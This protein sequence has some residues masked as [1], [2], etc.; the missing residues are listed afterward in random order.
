MK[1]ITLLLILM[2]PLL[3]CKGQNLLQQG[4]LWSNTVLGHIPGST[5]NSYFIKFM[6][7]TIL[8]GQGYKKIM[9]SDDALHAQWTLNGC[10]R[11]E[12]AT[13]KVYLFNEYT[14][15]DRLLYDF[16]LEKGD[17]I[18]I[19]DGK[20]YA[21]VTNVIHATFGSSPVIRKQICFFDSNADPLWIEGIGS[22]QGV[23][24]G[25]DTF[26]TTGSDHQLVCYS[27]NEQLV[28]HHPSFSSCFPKSRTV[29]ILDASL[30]WNVGTHCVYSG[31]MTPSDKWSTSFVHTE[32]DTLMNDKHY[33]KI[34]SCA[35]S[36]CGLKQFKS[37]IREEAG[38]VM[39]ANKTEE[40]TLYDFN[41]Q[42]GDTMILDYLQNVSRDIRLYIRVDSVKSIVFIQD[43]SERIVQ[44]V[45]V[46]DYYNSRLGDYSLNDVFVEGIGSLKFG[47]EYPMGLFITMDSQCSPSLLCFYSGAGLMYSNPEFN[48]C[49]LSTGILQLQQGKLVQ[50]FSSSHG[51]LEIQFAEAKSGKLIVFDLNGKR[52]LGQAVNRSGTQYCLPSSGIYLY[53]FE[54]DKGKVQTGKVM[55]M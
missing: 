23:L 51:M 7:D 49:Y 38:K 45:T 15:K 52:I 36:L 9:R 20:S 26:F 25:L 16:S 42:K 31:P 19:G 54:S 12:S 47:L 39:L 5:Y 55:V 6:G 37:F 35:D 2:L 24:D 41:L 3:L 28:Y 34:V 13:G 53:R 43:A 1:K 48:S 46:F 33:L 21:R 29:S 4:K 32:G 40:L 30:K 22:L 27:E 44:Y 18:L 17:S 8:N 50:V 11:E 10:I 14:G